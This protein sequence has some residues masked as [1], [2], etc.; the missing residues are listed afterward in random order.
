LL[1][2]TLQMHLASSG[3]QDISLLTFTIRISHINEAGHVTLTS[4]IT[5]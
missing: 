2:W 1:T 4:L 5:K 3:A